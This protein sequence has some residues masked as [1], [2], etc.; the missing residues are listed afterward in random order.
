MT[1]LRTFASRD[2]VLQHH[3][4]HETEAEDVSLF[5][6]SAATLGQLVLAGKQFRSHVCRSTGHRG[7]RTMQCHFPVHDAGF[8]GFSQTEI[9]DFRRV[10][11]VDG[12]DEH[13][14]WLD[15]A[16]DEALFMHA[17]QSLT[18]VHHQTLLSDIGWFDMQVAIFSPD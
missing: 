8:C 18:A 12:L 3:I 15:V 5:G 4:K 2:S 17:D 11:A 1:Y 7:L 9:A 13:V 10:D 16:M 6:V 14:L